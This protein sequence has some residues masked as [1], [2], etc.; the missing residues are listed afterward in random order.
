MKFLKRSL[1]VLLTLAFFMSGLPA[2]AVRAEEPAPPSTPKYQPLPQ[3]VQQYMKKVA[4]NTTITGDEVVR[5]IVQANNK[6]V[7]E[8]GQVEGILQ[9]QARI[10]EEIRKLIPDV[11]IHQSFMDLANG[12]SFDAKRSLIP[13]LAA[14]P[15][16]L[17]VQEAGH[18]QLAMKTAVEMTQAKAVW[19]ELKEKGRGMVVAVLDSGVDERH[20]DLTLDASQE[21]KWTE[22]KMKAKITELGLPGEFK[23]L[24]VPYGYN[25][26]DGNRNS[27]TGKEQHGQHVTGIIAANGKVKGVAPEAQILAMKVFPEGNR[28]ASSDDIL[29]ALEDSVKLGADIVNMSLGAYSGFESVDSAYS[30]AIKNA[31]DKGVLVFIAAGNAGLSSSLQGLSTRDLPYIKA[32]STVGTPSVFPAAISVAS[33]NNTVEYKNFVYINEKTDKNRLEFGVQ[34]SVRKADDKF[35]ELVDG[36]HALDAEMAGKNY[37]DKLVLVERGENTFAEKAKNVANTGAY[38]MVLYDY[39]KSNGQPILMGGIDGIDIFAATIPRADALKIVKRMKKEPIQLLFS[40]NPVAVGSS[41]G[42]EPSAFSSWGP[43]PE[44]DFKPEIAAPGGQIYSLI[45]PDS[46][47]VLSG[48]SMATPHM[49]GAAALLKPLKEKQGYTGEALLTAIYDSFLNTAKPVAGKNGKTLFSPRQQGAG[50]VQIKAAAENRVRALVQG[51]PYVELRA[52]EGRQSFALELKNEGEKPVSFKIPKL[53]VYTEVKRLTKKPQVDTVAEGASLKPDRKE[54]EIPAGGSVTVNFTLKPGK[55]KQQFV[56]GYITL[57][58]QTEGQPDLSVP[59]MGFHGDWDEAPVLDNL[60]IN[61]ERSKLMSIAPDQ[62]NVPPGISGATALFTRGSFIPQPLGHFTEADNPEEM[63]SF[64]PNGDKMFDN[65]YPRMGLL[66]DAYQIEYAIVDKPS[67]DAKV[68]RVL[69]RSENLLKLDIANFHR[70]NLTSVYEDKTSGYWNGELYNESTGKL[71]VAPEGQYYY[72]IGAYVGPK[73]KPQYT[74]IPVKIDVTPPVIEIL[75]KETDVAKKEQRIRAKFS[76]ERTVVPEDYIT[77]IKD[78]NPM[79]KDPMTG[80]PI[81]YTIKP[82]KGQPGVYD[83]VITDIDLS[84][85]HQI[86]VQCFDVAFNPAQENFISGA[87]GDKGQYYV[88]PYDPG[89]KTVLPKVVYQR[90]LLPKKPPEEHFTEKYSLYLQP[91]ADVDKILVDGAEATRYDYSKYGMGILWIAKIPLDSAKGVTPKIEGYKGEQKVFGP[92]SPTTFY[93]DGYKPVMTVEEPKDSSTI[94]DSSAP[95]TKILIVPD[96]TKSVTFSGTARD[97][98]DS[99]IPDNLRVRIGSNVAELKD[100]KWSYKLELTKDNWNR[101]WRVTADDKAGWAVTEK[102]RIVRESDRDRLA[103]V[104]KPATGSKGKGPELKLGD[105]DKEPFLIQIAKL[106]D[107]IL[108]VKGKARDVAELTIDGKQIELVPNTDEEKATFPQK[109]TTKLKLVAGTNA[110]HVVAKAKAKDMAGG[111]PNDDTLKEFVNKKV[112][113]LY[114][115]TPPTLTDLAFDPALASNGKLYIKEPT[116]I[117]VSGKVADDTFGYDFYLDGNHIFGLFDILQKGENQR[118]FKTSFHADKTGKVLLT[119][120]DGFG[121]KFEETYPIV[122]DQELP[123]ITFVKPEPV[124]EKDELQTIVMDTINVTF[125]AT[126]TDNSTEESFNGVKAV[127]KTLN[128]KPYNDEPVTQAGEYLFEVRAEDVAGNVV[129]KTRHVILRKADSPTIEGPADVV[130]PVG[131]KSDW[132]KVWNAKD[133]QGNDI[134]KTIKVEGTYDPNTPGYYTLTLIATDAQ[135]NTYSK[136]ITVRVKEKPV[137][138]VVADTLKVKQGSV[139]NPLRG[140]RAHDADNNDIT[141]KLTYTGKLDTEVP[142][143]YRITYHVEDKDGLT[144]ERTVTF[145]VVRVRPTWQLPGDEPTDPGIYVPVIPAYDTDY[146]SSAVPA[147]D[148]AATA[149]E[150]S[151]DQSATADAVPKTGEKTS[152]A[153]LAMILLA[154]AAGCGLLLKRRHDC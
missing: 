36:G 86:G 95:N 133:S 39:A 38:G 90:T 9:Q 67:A 52:F 80:T 66:R 56:E 142:G 16:V 41:E 45:G 5:V 57:Q 29:A 127:S 152:S 72:R 145:K 70:G 81:G 83:F 120:I 87:E 24:K 112:R 60:Y 48:T 134:S 3:S 82:V 119:A 140:V 65:L 131:E 98:H 116:D 26:A 7:F 77:I 113:V 73:S 111:L 99:I 50:L 25:Y 30:R 121:N 97:D 4:E 149:E 154:M 125:E 59:Y 53:K 74:Y 2:G 115:T 35:H 103:E 44:L 102:Y 54:F 33:I 144:A 42:A 143:E 92:I 58:S 118:D 138:D 18:Y 128:G 137:I 71:E 114:D 21:N 61:K 51:K 105:L 126:V 84:L 13:Q 75:S 28:Y 76:D 148:A 101:E 23:T 124:E 31:R 107:D 11:H 132:S 110:F 64:S 78:G 129:V 68:L 8:G 79:G 122:L 117:G 49:A 130:E 106:K 139:I 62:G 27:H 34:P 136:V 55:T 123:T 46:Y 151:K 135:G 19:D 32:D 96:D 12:F 91:S 10:Q 150:Q 14:I 89:T 43:T 147:G 94:T 47:S 141:D 108:T 1:A 69:G 146:D 88:Y 6:P 15:G 37:K 109:F 100:G 85:Q 40:A 153:A 104:F 63:I 20:P 17:N 22:E 93:I